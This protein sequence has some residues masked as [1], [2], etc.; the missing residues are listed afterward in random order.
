VGRW[1]RMVRR[2]PVAEIE[3]ETSYH[4]GKVKSVCMR[5][6]LYDVIVGNI[7]GV[8]SAEAVSEI[9]QS[10]KRKNKKNHRSR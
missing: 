3:I 4:A 5:N 1:V 6:P 10:H 7:P 2:T 8:L 9:Q